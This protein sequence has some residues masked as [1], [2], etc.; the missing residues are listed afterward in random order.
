MIRVEG[1]F[2]GRVGDCVNKLGLMSP[3]ICSGAVTNY[4]TKLATDY[5]IAT[6]SQWDI[7]EELIDLMGGN[8]SAVSRVL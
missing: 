8:R 4:K 1:G 3:T 7:I 5:L 2:N 6:T